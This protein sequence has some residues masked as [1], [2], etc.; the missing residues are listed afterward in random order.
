MNFGLCVSVEHGAKYGIVLEIIRQ[1][2]AIE[3]GSATQ[4]YSV[5]A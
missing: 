2:P 3:L 1:R 5:L 4:A